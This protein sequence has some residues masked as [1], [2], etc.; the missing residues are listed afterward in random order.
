MFL[1]ALAIG[2]TGS[3]HCIGMCGPIAMAAPVG[4]D[5]RIAASLVYHLAR[6]LSYAGIGFLFGGLGYGF[7][8]A[9][10]QQSLSIGG[11]IFLLALVW[12]PSIANKIN[13]GLGSTINPLKIAMA[14]QLKIN[15]W[16][17][18]FALGLLN[19]LL[20]CAMVYFALTGAI[21]LA[22]PI[23]GATFMFV[24][25]LG[26]LPTML[27]F[28]LGFNKISQKTRTVFKRVQP[29]I[30]TI[31]AI[32]FILRGLNLDIPFLSPSTN[33]ITGATEACN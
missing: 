14:K 13:S 19:G 17:A 22:E 5:H 29:I 20:P 8:M 11:G 18:V 4:K 1:P 10:V 25:G 12:L 9:G 30:L 3:A 6:L 27:I 26:T 2:F 32:L 31:V 16:P 21:I 15:R 23:L 7:S 28:S 33:I 24:F